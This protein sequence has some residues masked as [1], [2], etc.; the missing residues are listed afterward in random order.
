MAPLG[1]ASKVCELCRMGLFAEDELEPELA[2]IRKFAAYNGFPKWVVN[3]VVRR[4][5]YTGQQNQ[6]QDEP[7]REPTA[8]QE[9]DE[10]PQESP[11]FISL[12]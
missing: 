7:Q 3:R 11:V 2:N 8:N 12:P 5:L 1:E 10:Q 4:T 6:P 9:E